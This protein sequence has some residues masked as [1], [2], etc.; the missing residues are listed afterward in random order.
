MRLLRPFPVPKKP[1]FNAHRLDGALISLLLKTPDAHRVHSRDQACVNRCVSY[2]SDKYQFYIYNNFVSIICGIIMFFHQDRFIQFD[3]QV[4][5]QKKLANLHRILQG[6]IP[7]ISRIAVA[8]YD[9]KTEVL[10]TF[11]HSSGMNDPLP[12]YQASLDEAPSLKKIL[13]QGKPRVVNNL[14]LFQ[15]GEHEHTIRIG[16][17]GYAASYTR[18]MFHNGLI[19]GFQFFNSF[20]TD[21]FTES[22]LHKLDI[23]GQIVSLLIV[24]DLSVVGMMNAAVKT[25]QHIVH[26]RDP[27]TGNH[28]D[29]MS[30]YARLIASA[31][32]EKYQLDDVFIDRVF[33]FAPLHDIGKIAIPDK[34][35]L[36]SGPLDGDEFDCMKTHTVKGRQM[37]DDLVANFDLGGLKDIDIL[38]NIAEY[39]HEM[40]NGSG[41]PEGLKGPAIPIEARIVA[42]ADVFDALTSKRPYKDAWA[43]EAAFAFLQE[44]SGEK[45]DR[46]CVNALIAHEPEILRIQQEFQEDF[47]S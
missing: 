8:L 22:C 28:L 40:V 18:P 6:E 24:N 45:F 13:Q 35:L 25:T 37:I 44:L 34:I 11:L 26:F 31:L 23:Y 9:P 46:D 47:Y 21:V 39:H 1:P 17:Q 33:T 20:E 32:A 42:V 38:R 12:N 4:P 27:E 2:F 43:N 16:R 30:H 7:F 10:S 3:D 29:R 5:L 36:K 41:Y 14:I 15:N 19:F